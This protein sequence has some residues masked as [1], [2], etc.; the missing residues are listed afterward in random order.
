[1]KIENPLLVSKDLDGL[2]FQATLLKNG[3]VTLA[4]EG[5][6]QAAKKTVDA[7][8]RFMFNVRDFGATKLNMVPK[9]ADFTYKPAYVDIRRIESL[10]YGV[11]RSYIIS[12]IPD[13]DAKVHDFLTYLTMMSEVVQNVISQTIPGCKEY[14]S[15]LLE[16][17]SALS[18]ASA[19]SAIARLSTNRIAIE[20]MNKKFPG[21]VKRNDHLPARAS[22]A[23]QYDSMKDVSN[24]QDF[25]KE[26]TERS[27]AIRVD[28][29]S[30]DVNELNEMIS[31]VIMNIKRKGDITLN[32]DAVAAVSTYLYNLAEEIALISAFATFLDMTTHTLKIQVTEISDQAGV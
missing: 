21:I 32:P 5:F 30:K 12:S 25:L 17:V 3:E 11:V 20:N 19:S 28:K 22:I 31:R 16:D 1:M 14:F 24:C 9:L 29:A 2:K 27:A 15:L 7:F 23:K 6:S 26:L 10:N 8:S 13:T 4:T 18:S